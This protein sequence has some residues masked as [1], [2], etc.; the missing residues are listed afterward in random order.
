MPNLNLGCRGQDFWLLAFVAN[1]L[2]V[3]SPDKLKIVEPCFHIVVHQTSTAYVVALEQRWLLHSVCPT[4]TT[5]FVRCRLKLSQSTRKGVGIIITIT[6]YYS[7]VL[8]S[9]KTSSIMYTNT[10]F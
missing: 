10:M 8:L 1:F 4:P 7:E 5:C 6:I 2:F 9:I 3:A